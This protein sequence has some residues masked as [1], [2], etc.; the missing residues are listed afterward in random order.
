MTFGRYLW[1]RLNKLHNINQ[2]HY[3][4]ALTEATVV[5]YQYT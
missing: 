5:M 1:K 2:I 4:E 3:C